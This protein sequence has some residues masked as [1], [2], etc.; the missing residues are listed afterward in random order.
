MH[1]YQHNIADYRADTSHL[2]LLEHGIYRQLLDWYYLDE[3]PIPKETELVFRR[4][5]AKTEDEKKAVILVLNDFFLL[6]DGY[7]HARCESEIS[8]YKLKQDRARENGKQ[9]GRPKKTKEVILANPEKTKSEANQELLTNNQYKE[10]INKKEKNP[11]AD[12]SA[13]SKRGTRLPSDWQ[14]SFEDI[15]FCKTNRPDLQPDKV[16]DQFR[17]YWIAQTGVKATKLDWS[18]TW[19]NWVRNQNAGV[20]CLDKRTEHQRREDAS[21]RAIF[22]HRLKNETIEI[23]EIGGGDA[24]KLLG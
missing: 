23:N 1:Y 4:L 2:S 3:K 15:E 10:K 22:G 17:D 9:G 7:K 24:V 6:D 16:A 21:A 8:L 18:A 14:P 20:K 19:R 11:P 12:L 13:Q 5:S